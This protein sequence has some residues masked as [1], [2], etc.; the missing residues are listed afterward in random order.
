MSELDDLEQDFDV[1]AVGRRAPRFNKHDGRPHRV[2]SPCA[3]TFP[4]GGRCRGMANRM[5]GGKWYC[6]HHAPKEGA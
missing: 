6:H 5:S 4:D 1:R 3:Y 2:V